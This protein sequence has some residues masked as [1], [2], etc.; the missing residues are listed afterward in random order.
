[1]IFLNSFNVIEDESNSEDEEAHISSEESEDS[2]DDSE[3]D[4]EEIQENDSDENVY[5]ELIS[6]EF[7]NNI[8]FTT[9][10]T[11]DSTVP[12]VIYDDKFSYDSQK[13]ELITDL[14]IEI[15]SNKLPRFS[16]SAHK[17]NSAI[18]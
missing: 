18:R 2:E 16:C 5:K 13:G 14:N 15:G 1:M 8:N 7:I 17:V 3:K 6:P 4:T 9:T 10:S 12:R 11:T